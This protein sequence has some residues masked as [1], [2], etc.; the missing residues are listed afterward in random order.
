[1]LTLRQHSLTM[2]VMLRQMNID[3]DLLGLHEDTQ[4]WL[5]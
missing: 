4:Q 1:M 5:T 3:P 2:A